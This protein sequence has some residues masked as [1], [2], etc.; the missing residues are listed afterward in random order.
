[1]KKKTVKQRIVE[2]IGMQKVLEIT[3]RLDGGN[4]RYFAVAPVGIEERDGRFYLLALDRHDD[5][6]AFDVARIA[7]IGEYWAGYSLCNGFNIEMLEDALFNKGKYVDGYIM[8]T[9]KNGTEVGTEQLRE[10]LQT[11]EAEIKAIVGPRK[12]RDWV[13]VP[14]EADCEKLKELLRSRRRCLNMM[15]RRDPHGVE[16]FVRV[17]N[18]LRE[19]SDLMYR[20][21][22]RVYRQYLVAGIDGEFDDD[23][24]I[25]A[26]LRFVYNS[27]ESIIGIGDEEY[28]GSDFDYMVN[29]IYD[30]CADSPLAGASF[31]KGFR[32]TD[33]PEMS[34]R[35]LELDNDSDAFDWSEL[36][37]T[38]PELDGIKI[39]NA[40][41]AMCVYD[42]G[43]SVPD[44]LRM[45]DFWCEVKATYQHICDQ[46]GKRPG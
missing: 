34:D 41:N 16:C 32:K 11:I 6:Y 35:E 17:N 13:E 2:A 1:M 31:S 38:I 12:G 15:F 24:M 5:G 27:E 45:N 37:I 10:E 19:L 36:K 26:S 25:E 28:Y 23:F 9:K 29:V 39:C 7:T 20:K 44:L 8:A 18:R 14:V 46:N 4:D 21:G 30:L 33:R 22:A 43:Y 42:N 40:V 3:Y